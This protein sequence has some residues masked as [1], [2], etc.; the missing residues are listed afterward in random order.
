MTMTNPI[1]PE[2]SIIIPAYNTATLV[3]GCLNSVFAQTYSDFEAIVVNDGS[4]DTPE[5]EMVLAPYLDRIVYIRQENK[6]AAGARN[7]AIRHARGRFLAFLDS[8]DAWLPEHLALQ[9]KLFLQEPALDLVYA[10]SVVV[11]DPKQTWRFMERCPSQG[12]ATF[13]ALVVER[14]QIPVS[15]VVARRSVL[16]AANLFDESLRCFDDY[17]MWLRA[18]FSG[19]RISYTRQV[20]ARLSGKRPGSLSQSA[21]K[22]ADAY[23][24][25]LEKSLRT[26]PLSPSQR[27]LIVRRLMEARA[28]YQ[29][30]EAN[31]ELSSRHFA[32]AKELLRA[33]NRHL[34]RPEVVLAVL[35]LGIAPNTTCK[36]IEFSRRLRSRA[37]A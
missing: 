34:R 19:A 35:A 37:S 5:L 21:S 25:I 18:A 14:C 24:F 29:L 22:M 36:F 32:K 13:A 15:T 11:G 17:D 16:V 2:V 8:D 31:R 3:A 4:P 1:L 10:D 33:A 27:D 23:L 26:L 6:G 30:A 20:Q 28:A 7:T 9:M 12:E